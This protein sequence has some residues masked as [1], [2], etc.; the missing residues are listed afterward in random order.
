MFELKQKLSGGNLADW[1]SALR[2]YKPAN[3]DGDNPLTLPDAEAAIIAIR[4]ARK[5]KWYDEAPPTDEQLRDMS[6]GELL[7]LSD[8]V[9]KLFSKWNKRQ[10]VT[11]EEKKDFSGTPP[12]S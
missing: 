3:F 12:T 9:M 11:D 2:D 10:V 5:A 1:T 4:A 8:A 6:L 7:D